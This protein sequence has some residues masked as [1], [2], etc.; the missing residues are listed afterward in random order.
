MLPQYKRDDALRL[1]GCTTARTE[2]ES[3]KAEQVQIQMILILHPGDL[4][5]WQLLGIVGVFFIVIAL[6]ISILGLLIYKI[7]KR[8]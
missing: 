7:I 6:P 8:D 2:T 4:S 5:A 1:V 3:V